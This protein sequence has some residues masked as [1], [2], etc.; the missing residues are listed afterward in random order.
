[1]QENP[2]QYVEIVFLSSPALCSVPENRKPLHVL[3]EATDSLGG[4]P[5]LLKGTSLW[6][7]NKP[8][9]YLSMFKD[10]ISLPI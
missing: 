1:M 2:C 3:F 10:I 7:I 6:E 9:P 4:L 8:F 5:C